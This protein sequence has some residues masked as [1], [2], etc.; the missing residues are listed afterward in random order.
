[1][2]VYWLTRPCA[3]CLRKDAPTQPTIRHPAQ[4]QAVIMNDSAKYNVFN[5]S[6]HLSLD[7]VVP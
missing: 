4:F 7:V 5:E 2:V 6:T 3:F 1:M